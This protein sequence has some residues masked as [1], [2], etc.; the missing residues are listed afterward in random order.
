MC[1]YLN[2]LCIYYNDTSVRFG[3]QIGGVIRKMIG[4]RDISDLTFSN[5]HVRKSK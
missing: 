2:E 3:T 5:L 4:Y 1:K